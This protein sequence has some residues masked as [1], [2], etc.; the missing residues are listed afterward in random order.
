MKPGI[1]KTKKYAKRK[2]FSLVKEDRVLD[3]LNQGYSVESIARIVNATVPGVYHAIRRINRRWKYPNDPKKGRERGFL[4]DREIEM[5]RMLNAGSLYNQYQLGQMFYGLSQAAI[6]N[7]CA[8]KTYADHCEDDSL[9]E[10]DFSPNFA[11]CFASG[12]RD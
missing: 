12:A 3:L 11:N 10:F 6:N 4:S 9:D 7:I 5:I 1:A 8:K 2:R